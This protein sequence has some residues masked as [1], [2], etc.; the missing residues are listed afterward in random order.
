MRL[1]RSTKLIV[2]STPA[3]AYR[4]PGISPKAYE[5]PAD[6]AATAAL[7]AIPLLDTYLRRLI[8]FQYERAL[9]QNFLAGSL[10]IGPR[11]L[12]EIWEDYEH[13]LVALD[14]PGSY[15]LYVTQWPLVNAA[16][17][18]S[19]KPMI[20]LNSGLVTLVDREELTTVM[21]HGAG[22]ILSD[23]VLYRTAL[24]LLLNAS[25]A[26]RLPFLAG[27]PLMAI[28]SALLEWYRASELS[29]D[30]AATL[31]NRDPLV[32]C[33]TM[34]VLA[35]GIPSEKLDLDAFLVQGSE[36]EEWD[37][38]WD[39]LSRFF[40]EAGLTHSHPVRRVSELMSWVRSGDY[41]RIVGG[42]YVRRGE[43]PPARAEAGDAVDYYT[44]RFRTILGEAGDTVS[45]AGDRLSDWIRG[46]R[47]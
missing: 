35:A 31:V 2:V 25:G 47:E 40:S 1:R 8:E 19:E 28:R 41:D 39:K 37:S 21:G 7:R 15:D 27:L 46:G 20:V 45:S 44:E 30:R 3:E 42:E 4:L 22:H 16:A 23:H 26:T 11:Q 29:C 43:E 17:V 12:P 32:T 13:A 38:G 9:R 24:L 33:R 5:H 6:R 14:M 10:K 36:Y 18:G 34:M